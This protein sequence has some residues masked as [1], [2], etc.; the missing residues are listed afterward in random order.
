MVWPKARFQAAAAFNPIN[1]SLPKTSHH[2]H[3]DRSRFQ[4]SSSLLHFFKRSFRR[5]LH[6]FLLLSLFY[7]LLLRISY[8][9][10]IRNIFLNMHLESKI[11]L[12]FDYMI[13]KKSNNCNYK[14][15][16]NENFYLLDYWLNCGALVGLSQ[17]NNFCKIKEREIITMCY[18]K[19][20][21]VIS[22][23]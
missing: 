12:N 3:H 10:F 14:M 21:I 13:M 9:Y 15:E 4:F 20:S 17:N 19:F 23:N 22:F 11:I 5:D 6:N 18:D 8:F 2:H 1:L 7:S 16:N